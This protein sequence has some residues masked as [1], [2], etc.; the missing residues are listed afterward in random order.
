MTTP[1]ELSSE[2]NGTSKTT[3]TMGPPVVGLITSSDL[4][5]GTTNQPPRTPSHLTPSPGSPFFSYAGSLS[6]IVSIS[7]GTRRLLPCATIGHSSLLGVTRP[8]ARYT[9][10]V[11]V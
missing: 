2:G 3:A 5:A 9:S 8:Y 6:P 4:R 11:V 10:A 7:P 1:T